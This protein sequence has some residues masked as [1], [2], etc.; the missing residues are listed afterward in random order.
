L[1]VEIWENYY[2][3]GGVSIQWPYQEPKLEVP[4]IYK[5]LFSG[6]NFR[7]YPFK[8]MAKHM[9]LTYLH[10]LDPEIPIDILEIRYP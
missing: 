6:L 5:A 7:E 4:T 3:N 1:E 10:Q 2:V 8:N 9:V